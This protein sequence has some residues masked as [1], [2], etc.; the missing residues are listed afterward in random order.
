MKV[1]LAFPA[2]V[3]AALIGCAGPGFSPT[4]SSQPSPAFRAAAPAFTGVTHVSR[5]SNWVLGYTEYRGAGVPPFRWQYYFG[6]N[7]ETCQREA[8]RYNEHEGAGVERVTRRY[9]CI[10][11]IRWHDAATPRQAK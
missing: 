8:T 10:E 3:A 7:K 2:V 9:Y 1:F 4:P 11:Q 6:G 5:G